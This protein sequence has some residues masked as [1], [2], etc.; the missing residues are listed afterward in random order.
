[1]IC[2]EI[3]LEQR[4]NIL[5]TS[6]ES[7]WWYRVSLKKLFFLGIIAFIFVVPV[8]LHGATS[9]S[10]NINISSLEILD[11]HPPLFNRNSPLVIAQQNPAD[12]IA[13]E[14]QSLIVQS[15]R[16]QERAGRFPQA[17]VRERIRVMLQLAEGRAMDLRGIESRGGRVLRQRINLVTAEI[18]P[19]Q[20][21]DVIRN[22][23]EIVFAR[24]PHRFSPLSV[25]SEAVAFTDADSLHTLGYNGGGV[26]VAVLD[27]GFKGLTQAIANNDLPAGVITRD[28]TGKG[29]ETQYKHGTACAEIVHDMAPYAELYLLK[30]ADEEDLYAAYEYCLG[31]SVNIFSFSIGIFGSGPG[32]GT[33]PIDDFF[34]EVRA[35]GIFVVAAVGN[36]ANLHSVDNVPLGTHWQGIFTDANQ[37][38]IHEFTLGVQGNILLALLNHDDDG[39]PEY[40]EATIVMRWNDWPNAST[41][42]DMYLYAYDYQARTRGTM[43]AYSTGVQNGSQPPREKIVVDLPENLPNQFYELAIV[44]KSGSPAGKELEITTAGGNSYFIGATANA[45]PIATSAGS[46]ME[47]A[48]AASVFAVG[49][50]NRL[51]WNTGPQESYSSQGPTNAWAGSAARIKPDI[52]GPDGVST[53]TYGTSFQG[54]SA[55]APHVAG[56]A[57]LLK[58][59][60]PNLLP[61]EIQS[62]LESWALDMG[63]AGKDNLYGWGKLRLTTYQLSTSKAGTGTG[64][65]DSVPNGIHCGSLCS[66]T[67]ASGMTVDM[68]ATADSDSTF[69]GWSGACS[70]TGQCTVTMNGAKNVSATFNKTY[71][72]SISKTGSGSGMVK[73]IPDALNCCSTCSLSYQAGTSVTLTAW[74]VPGSTFA[75]WS[76]GGCAGTGNCLVTINNNLQ[77]TALFSN[78]WGNVKNDDKIDIADAILALQVLSSIDTSEN[79]ITM[80]ADTNIDG[81]IGMAE[82]IYILQKVAGMR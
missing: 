15:R 18:P 61:A 78:T 31:Q 39:N 43:V 82:V 40:D 34:N 69:A 67:Y 8:S 21:E 10:G 6:S 70:G 14:L 19:D 72:L 17:A 28:F 44:R 56:A 53:N 51:Q 3:K 41:D 81:K 58:S 27:V 23:P 20:I 5:H 79:T 30:I 59:L 66:A 65:I 36:G 38:M 13:P 73:S 37:D 32:D 50:I 71:V 26:K 47:P 2:I 63:I 62:Y 68:T 9:G 12:R 49:A 29:L 54:T 48:D 4:K 35:N 52:S 74:P 22:D 60:H 57:A 24:L 1:M 46:I 11:A 55:A 64:T 16:F 77:I 75:G 25:T 7:S 45:E 33:G 76:G 42:Y 80:S